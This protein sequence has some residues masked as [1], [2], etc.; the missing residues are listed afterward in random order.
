MR[1]LFLLSLLMLSGVI[2][3][4]AQN[5][6]SVEQAQEEARRF[7]QQPT[8]R[9]ASPS[10]TNADLKLAYTYNDSL[11]NKP[12]TYIFN[13]GGGGFVIVPTS[14]AAGPIWGYST[15]G[16]CNSTNMPPQLLAVLH[17][18]SKKMRYTSEESASRHL[19]TS[20]KSYTPITPILGDRIWG[21]DAPYNA[22]C[23]LKDGIRTVSGCV[24]T[25][26]A[27]L[28][29]V[30]QWPKQGKGEHQY[31]WNGET[32][33]VDFSS[34]TYDWQHMRSNCNEVYTK[35]ERDAIGQLVYH[36][37]VACDMNYGTSEE[38]GSGSS[39]AFIMNGL[40]DY[41]SYDADI[42]P[43][44]RDYMSEEDFLTNV[45]QELAAGH[46]CY[47]VAR[48]VTNSGH[49]FL[50]DGMDAQGLVHINW[51][52]NGM[53]DGYYSTDAMC[54]TEQGTGGSGSSEGYT[55]NVTFYT[56]IRPDQGGTGHP[57]MVCKE[58]RIAP[59][60][61]LGTNDTTYFTHIN[62]SNEGVWDFE[63]DYVFIIYSETMQLKQVIPV[64]ES[65]VLPSGYYYPELDFA[66]AAKDVHL[67]PG[68]YYITTGI[69]TTTETTPLLLPEGEKQMV[70]MT[71]TAD[72]RII[73][74]QEV[75]W[76]VEQ[77]IPYNFYYLEAD[78][79]EASSKPYQWK[80]MF[81][82]EDFFESDADD[83]ANG[84]L[85]LTLQS[86]NDDSF[87]GFYSFE[88]AY[89]ENEYAINHIILYD[90][91]LE[92]S[93]MTSGGDGWVYIQYD[94]TNLY[95]LIEYRL[96]IGDD[97]RYG[98]F[99]M[100]ANVVFAFDESNNQMLLKEQGGGN[101]GNPYQPE[102]MKVKVEGDTA[103]FSWSVEKMP[104]Y[105]YAH[106]FADGEELLNSILDTTYF[107][108][109]SPKRV[110]Y[111]WAAYSLDYDEANNEFVTL[112]YNIQQ[113][114]I[115]TC[116]TP[117]NLH[118]EAIDD[119]TYSLSWQLRD[120]ADLYYVDI[121][122]TNETA[123]IDMVGMRTDTTITL[124][125]N[126][127]YKWKI[128]AYGRQDN[129]YST[130]G[131]AEGTPFIVDAGEDKGKITQLQAEPSGFVIHYSWQGSAPTYAIMIYDQDGKLVKS[132]YC[133]TNSYTY[134]TDKEGIHSFFVRPVSFYF[135][136]ASYWYEIDCNVQQSQI[137]TGLRSNDKEDINITKIIKNG[138]LFILR[139]NGIYNTQGMKVKNIQ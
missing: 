116:Y 126:G 124:L 71:I 131:E 45:H 96:K 65:N 66:L 64:Y 75:D 82:T 73:I 125:G 3:S 100:S 42:R 6:R 21:Q 77:S 30:H 136:L 39:F 13:R 113:A 4:I 53:M 29:C 123:S 138:R 107:T 9:K 89:S 18:A 10:S 84:L 25:A 95:Y 40:H 19:G 93:T 91:S 87:V 99:A 114:V 105:V 98:K 83:A 110:R 31:E 69:Q 12:F 26:A 80:L 92:R 22:Y 132:D 127:S 38:G 17:M 28:M 121:M 101:D 46:P 52:W 61:T 27:Q 37:G 70:G 48:T 16:T 86:P 1:K 51:G 128:I 24:A 106:V 15:N 2:S 137:V 57:V 34:A 129:Y 109:Y 7:F 36:V 60:N 62:L 111:D 130:L 20:A 63:G 74:N 133:Q 72:N 8:I 122:N 11:T 85:L 120:T 81:V 33:H 90:G 102:Y 103:Y 76:G 112:G 108:L 35:E 135:W 134:T 56:G 44:L 23:P 43:L 115:P 55:E 54:P 5:V 32:L 97:W 68:K 50:C 88:G 78:R 41:F 117:F 79:L 67:A 14:S 47:V 119:T 104:P 118:A 94:D 59:Y 58:R 49:A 139:Q